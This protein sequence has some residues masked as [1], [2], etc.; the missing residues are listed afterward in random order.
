MRA[1]G[2]FFAVVAFVVR[3]APKRVVILVAA[4]V[5]VAVL[6][7]VVVPRGDTG[8]GGGQQAAT[9]TRGATTQPMSQEQQCQR[10]ALGFTRS[11][12]DHSAPSEEWLSNVGSWVPSEMKTQLGTIDRDKIPALAPTGAQVDAQPGDYCEV[13][14]EFQGGAR[15]LPV[16]VEN[17]DEGWLATSW[18]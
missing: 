12:M 1:I 2:R 14:V 9:P 10:V 8:G 6:L 13:T 18:G 11:F 15:T 5:A 4:L 17:T 7:M 16:T 3:T